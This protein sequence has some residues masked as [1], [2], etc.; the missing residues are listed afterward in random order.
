MLILGACSST[1]SGN[2]TAGKSSTPPSNSTGTTSSA[3]SSSTSAPVVTNPVHVSLKLSD[4]AQVGV[5]MP[6]IAF[7]SRPVVDLKAFAAATKVTVNHQAVTGAWFCEEFTSK[8]TPIECDWRMENYW[9]GH[10]QIHMDLPVKGVSAGPG[11]AFDDSLTS[12]FATGPANILT[13]DAF[14]HKLTVVSDGTQWGQFPVSLGARDTPTE[15]GVKVIMEKG[16]SICMTGPGY[17]E[18]GVKYTQRLTYGGEYLHAAPWNV[19][20]IHS[21]VDSSNG[22]TNLTL[23]DAKKLYDFL[24]IGDVVNYPNANGK[25]M[26]MGDGYGDWN[27]PWAQWLTGGLYATS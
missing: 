25:H 7:L 2:G 9:P 8:T 4:G 18:C 24:E 19:S 23:E 3:P 21:G 27:V 14:T 15:H 17:H 16:V 5:G 10:A 6:I 22:C 13:V 11:L 1:G 20:H 12:D 26:A